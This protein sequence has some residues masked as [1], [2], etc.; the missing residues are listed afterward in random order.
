MIMK[1]ALQLMGAITTTAW[2]CKCVVRK[3]GIDLKSSKESE[4]KLLPS[5]DALLKSTSSITM[6]DAKTRSDSVTI[7]ARADVE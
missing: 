3:R 1:N 7:E 4:R 2:W 5:A 6:Q